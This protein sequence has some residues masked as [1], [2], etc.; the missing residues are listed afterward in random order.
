MLCRSTEASSGLDARHVSSYVIFTEC[1]QIS[2][3]ICPEGSLLQTCFLC[4]LRER[5]QL[6]QGCCYMDSIVQLRNE[7]FL[8]T[9]SSKADTKQS[10]GQV[11][12][13]GSK[14]LSYYSHS[15]Q[16]FSIKR[17]ESRRNGDCEQAASTA[18]FNLHMVSQA[19][20]KVPTWFRMGTSVYVPLFTAAWPA[21]TLPQLQAINQCRRQW[22]HSLA[23]LVSRGTNS[24]SP[25][26]SQPIILVPEMHSRYHSPLAAQELYQINC[27]SPCK[28][29]PKGLLWVSQTSISSPLL[30]SLALL[31]CIK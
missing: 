23:A 10:T 18:A 15:P 22:Q 20:L 3:W 24:H 28:P 5:N 17:W 27:T 2:P 16:I 12:C 31:K 8:P 13:G 1:V 19:V 11:N 9:G 29:Q 21:N 7:T 30:Q 25:Y 4:C 26:K 6:R 14:L